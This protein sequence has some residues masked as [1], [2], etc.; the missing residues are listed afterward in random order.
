LLAAPNIVGVDNLDLA[1]AFAEVLSIAAVID[2]DNTCATVAEWRIGAGRGWDDLVYVGLGTGIGGGMVTS[3]ALRRG[4][5]GFAGELGH[6]IVDPAGPP[7]PCGKR[8]CWERYGSG[9]GLAWLAE[10]AGLA[11][12]SPSDVLAAARAD[13]ADARAVRAEFVRYVALGLANLTNV[14]D[15]QGFVLGGGVMDDG[16][17]L[18]E[19]IGHELGG[20]LY[21]TELG[22]P[23]PAVR[24][25]RFGSRSAAIGAALLGGQ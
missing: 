15:P 14:L 19:L 25:A 11:A 8:G 9:S 12:S 6:M 4:A 10:R 2:N 13:G 21:G 5:H 24:R 1:G 23:T 17:D 3:G 20:A 18:V 22:R 16:D 7:C